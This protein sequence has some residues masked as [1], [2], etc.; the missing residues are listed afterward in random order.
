M[1]RNRGSLII[2]L[3]PSHRSYEQRKSRISEYSYRVKHKLSSNVT[4]SG[5]LR[6]L[7][8]VDE[9]TLEN[10]TLMEVEQLEYDHLYFGYLFLHDRK[11]CQRQ[12]L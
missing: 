10:L 2:G 6:V 5:R 8:V 1:K 3:V 12:P 7:K 9:T 11:S 4:E